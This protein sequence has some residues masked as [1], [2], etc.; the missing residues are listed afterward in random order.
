MGR[1]RGTE[2]GLQYSRHRTG[3]AGH[4][5]GRHGERGI[6]MGT[7]PPGQTCFWLFSDGR[8]PRLCGGSGV[9]EAPPDR[10]ARGE[11]AESTGQKGAPVPPANPFLLSPG[12]PGPHPAARCGER[13]AEMCIRDR[14]RGS[15]AVFAEP[16]LWGRIKKPVTRK[17]VSGFFVVRKF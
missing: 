8:A 16:P 15:P 6:K 4:R 17:K 14:Q 10:L 3:T 9:L 2:R 5:G 12:S 13:K 11:D 7:P 1:T